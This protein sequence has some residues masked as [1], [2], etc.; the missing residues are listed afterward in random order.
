MSFT[1]LD[2]QN[3]ALN[4]LLNPDYLDVREV[5]YGGRKGGGKS[6]L[7]CVF[8]TQ[9]ALCYPNTSYFVSRNNLTDLR[10]HTLPSFIETFEKMNVSK[11][12]YK[13]NGQDNIITFYNGSRIIF[14]STEYQPSDPMYQRFGSMQNTWGWIEEGGE[15]CQEAYSN[16]V[17][18]IGRCKN[19]EYNISAYKLLITANPQ[20]GWMYDN[21][22]KNIT[23]DRRY[24]P[25]GATENYFLP[26]EYLDTLNKITD[27]IQRQ[28]LLL[29]DWDYDDS[30]DALINSLKIRDLFTNSFVESGDMYIS[31]DI[32]IT[33]DRFVI[34]V[35][36]GLRIVDIFVTRNIGAV[37]K[38]F[39][40]GVEVTKVNYQNL[41][42]KINYYAQLY[43]VPRSNI[44]YDADGI[45]HNIQRLLGGATALHTGMESTTGEYFNL[46]SELYFR[47][48]ELIN[49]NKIYISADISD[50]LKD[51]IITE[52]SYV[53]R[54]SL[55]GEKLRI[56]PKSEIK[57]I[58]NKSPD[59]SDAI[60]YGLF[61]YIL[62]KKI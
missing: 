27:K 40:N 60:V 9:S 26:K 38:E 32:A 44:C 49:N 56:K 16:L 21:F 30:E 7:G 54:A 5:L 25:A 52:L 33:N 57:K 24:I 36:S 20:K 61:L 39:E 6:F 17:L 15:Q 50:H 14:V 12:M 48:S 10:K 13:F 45:G 43:H 31:C 3:E 23:S 1:L 47:L 46:R 18:S 42:D 4:Y 19:K 2:S 51:D 62:R 11:I 28:R 53:K 55:V 8:L 35:W 34:V 29:G 22:F 41:T 59:I 37:Q 58:I